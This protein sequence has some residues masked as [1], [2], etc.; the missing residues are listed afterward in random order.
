M[1]RAWGKVVPLSV[2]NPATTNSCCSASGRAV[3]AKI[4]P[5]ATRARIRYFML[6]SS[7]GWV[8]AG[9]LGDRPFITVVSGLPRSGTSMMMQM[10]AAGG[11]PIL[12]DGIR[13]A[14]EDNPR[15]YFEFEAVKRTKTDPSWVP[16]AV[17]KAVKI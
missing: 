6:G 13:T 14:D 5:L 16:T 15:G 17:G 1:R 2:W 4:W 3:W 12:T 10:L 8:Y 11:M 9:K 7:I